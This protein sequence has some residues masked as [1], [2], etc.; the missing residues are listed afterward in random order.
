MEIYGKL[1]TNYDI[2]EE[3]YGAVDSLN[4]RSCYPESKKMGEN[5]CIAYKE[6]Y[7]N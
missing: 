4:V 2:K 3:E 7:R 6:Q 1:E 5:L